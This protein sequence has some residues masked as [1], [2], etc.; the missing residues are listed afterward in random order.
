MTSVTA[1]CQSILTSLCIEHTAMVDDCRELKA[2]T[3]SERCGSL[4]EDILAL[5]RSINHL[6]L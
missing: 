3:L 4:Q 6:S 5:Q 2:Q 1:S